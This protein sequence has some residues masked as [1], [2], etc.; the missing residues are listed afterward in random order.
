M[1]K[2][3][4]FIEDI[5]RRVLSSLP[6]EGKVI[7]DDLQSNIKHCIQTAVEKFDMVSR[8]EFDAEKQVLKDCKA[9][10]KTLEEQ[11]KKLHK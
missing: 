7:K 6:Q 10:I 5:T 1:K 2:T 9:K 11:V 8:E 4:Q 3:K